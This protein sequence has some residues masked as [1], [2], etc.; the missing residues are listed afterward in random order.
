MFQRDAS[1]LRHI[2]ITPSGVVAYPAGGI[3]MEPLSIIYISIDG[4]SSDALQ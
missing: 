2:A 4:G 1:T 3:C